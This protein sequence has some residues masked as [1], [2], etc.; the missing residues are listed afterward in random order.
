MSTSAVFIL[1]SKG[2]VIISRNYRGDIPMSIANK[3]AVH[4]QD[5]DEST[6]LPIYNEEGITFINVKHNNLYFLSVTDRNING[7]VAILFLYRLIEVLRSYFGEV[8]EESIRDNFV[9]IYELFDEMMDFG[10]PQ[11]TDS[12]ILSSYILEKSN[13]L[14]GSSSGA[15]AGAITKT[16]TGAVNW[17]PENIVY[18]KNEVFLDVVESVN[19]LV[20]AKG[21]VLRSEVLGAIKMNVHLSGMPELRLGLNDKVQIDTGRSSSGRGGSGSSG[22]SSG[23]E[24]RRNTIEM[25]DVH[26][27][28]C[29]KLNKFD[30]SH[31]ITF[32]P[33]DGEFELMTY[34]LSTHV[35]PMIWIEAAIDRHAHSRIEYIIKAKSQF[36]SQSI[37]NNVVIGIPVP[38][39]VHTPKFK[40]AVGNVKYFPEQDQMVWSIKE[41][42]GDREFL[43]RAHFEL[44][45]TST[46]E[47]EKMKKPIS[48]KFEIPYFTVSGMHI[49]YLKIV[50]KSGY[51][52]MPWV[53]Y[54]TRSG[55]YQ[56][57]T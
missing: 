42:P 23:G 54:I 11:T 14:E 7:A 6:L 51:A 28:Q 48:V 4:I 46:E 50:E 36:K 25:E 15:G 1:D 32:V 30:V 47:D 56:I 40:S 20:S 49:R 29:V 22:G 16:I 2:K 24:R 5:E 9:I 33:P 12:K 26:F 37:A 10:Y 53:R 3:F 35:K 27:H 44:T 8:C 21:Q 19:I 45:S 41:F 17:R 31:A 39:D 38:A 43:M 13:R 57:R 18:S 52:A 55:D 34:R